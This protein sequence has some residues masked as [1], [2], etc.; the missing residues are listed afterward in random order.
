[1][2][3]V[4]GGILI[5][6]VVLFLLGCVLHIVMSFV[7]QIPPKKPTSSSQELHKEQVH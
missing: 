1:M 6:G 5:G 2:L 7:D 4:A 3:T